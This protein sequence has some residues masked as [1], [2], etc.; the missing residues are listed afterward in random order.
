[1]TI[2]DFVL[3]AS[4]AA[5]LVVV[6]AAGWQLQRTQRLA[7]QRLEAALAETRAETAELRARL[8]ALTASMAPAPDPQAEQ[9]EWVITAIGDEPEAPAEAVQRIEGRL[10]AD[11]VL[12]ETVVKAA[13]LG[14]GVRRVLAPE[15]R[16]RIRFQMRQETKRLRKERK[17]TV[18]QL[19]REAAA[20]QRASA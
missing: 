15:T 19:Q 20:R 17:A 7:S 8:D 5:L 4:L 10:F 16:N 3:P 6:V 13:S 18:R 1:M 11:I 2:P 12:R 9:R 14:H